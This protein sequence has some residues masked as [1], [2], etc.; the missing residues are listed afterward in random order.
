MQ[1]KL[2]VVVVVVVASVGRNRPKADAMSDS[3]ARKTFC[4]GHNREHKLQPETV[5]ENPLAPG[6]WSL[7]H[8]N[9]KDMLILRKKGKLEG[10]L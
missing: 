8:V 1:I 10:G 5:Q 2:V 9:I 4:A 6:V 7:R 3:A